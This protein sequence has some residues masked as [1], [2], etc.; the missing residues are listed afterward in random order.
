MRRAIIVAAFVCLSALVGC[1]GGGGG[2]GTTQPSPPPQAPVQKP[3]MFFTYFGE[4]DNQA[5]EVMEHTNIVM[6]AT[7]Y[8]TDYER[9]QR[10]IAA[11]Q[12]QSQAIV[13]LTGFLWQ[14]QGGGHGANT[15]RPDREAALRWYLT[16][17]RNNGLLHKVVAFY[18]NDEPDYN[19]ISVEHQRAAIE[20]VRRVASEFFPPDRM[21]KLAVIYGS[22]R[23]FPGVELYDWIGTDEYSWG[24][25][26]FDKY[27]RLH[28]RLRPDQWTFL[29]PG[30]NN[31]TGRQDPAPFVEFALA[32]PK[33]I[34]VVAF[35]WFDHPEQGPGIRSNG[36][37]TQYCEAGKRVTG[38]TGPC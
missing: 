38:K 6:T 17:L 20:L 22:T 25:G 12:T 34:G 19:R 18:P 36:L 33:V 13:D 4:A 32:N 7:W 14:A 9:A 26:V 10:A 21:P 1:G 27:E 11:M 15:P 30:G 37:R 24:T 2:Q 16:E 5:A 29:V 31:F 8:G 35:I 28:E 3:A 23:D